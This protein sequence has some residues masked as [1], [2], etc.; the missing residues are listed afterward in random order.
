VRARHLMQNR[1]Q[2]VFEVAAVEPRHEFILI[3]IVG[4]FGVREIAEL[5]AVFEIVDG[6]DI[7][8]TASIECAHE[9]GS[10]EPGAAGNDDIHDGNLGYQSSRSSAPTRVATKGTR[11]ATAHSNS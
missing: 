2:V 3:E 4:D 11:G 5:S 8:F 1:R 9:V 6:D 10:D 7:G